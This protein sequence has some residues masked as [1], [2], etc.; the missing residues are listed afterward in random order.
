[1]EDFAEIL[2]HQ[3]DR[4]QSLKVLHESQAGAF[5]LGPEEVII[6]VSSQKTWT[7]TKDLGED[8]ENEFGFRAK[9]GT[10]AKTVEFDFHDS[11]VE[12]RSIDLRSN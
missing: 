5:H 1:M 2:E 8:N 10:I 12:E 3:N 6:S 9:N 7:S 4:M 11:S